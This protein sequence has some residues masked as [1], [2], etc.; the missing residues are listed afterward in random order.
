MTLIE[1]C[2]KHDFLV[3]EIKKRE[4]ALSCPPDLMELSDTRRALAK[5][6]AELVKTYLSK[7]SWASRKETVSEETEL[8]YFN[9]WFNLHIFAED[10]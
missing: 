9:T 3:G 1:M 10:K 8:L 7:L 6:I 4:L 5:D 2:K